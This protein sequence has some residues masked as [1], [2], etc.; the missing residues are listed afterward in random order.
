MRVLVLHPEDVPWR[1]EWNA[2][3]WDLIVDLGFA[4]PGVYQE[5]RKRTGARVITLHQFAGQTD[6]YRWVNHVL[7]AGRGKFLDRRGLDWWEILAPCSY[8]Q[9]QALYLAGRF[10][11]EVMP[12]PV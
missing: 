5:W 9:V 8:D 12:G 2:T 4:G 1:G 11:Q 10:R 3:R 6:S 7:E